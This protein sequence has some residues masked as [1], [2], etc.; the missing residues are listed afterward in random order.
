MLNIHPKNALISL[1]LEDFQRWFEKRYKSQLIIKRDKNNNIVKEV[2]L[3]PVLI[4]YQI[5]KNCTD[6]QLIYHLDEILWNQKNRRHFFRIIFSKIPVNQQENWSLFD[7]LKSS[8]C[9]PLPVYL[10][11]KRPKKTEYHKG[12][13]DHG[14]LGSDFSKILKEQARTEEYQ[15]ILRQEQKLEQDP[16]DF[17]SALLDLEPLPK[18]GDS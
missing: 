14:S 3:P 18:E 7:Y 15:E 9:L 8:D 11:K 1:I 17:L 10:P 6:N 16:I 4:Q 2:N 5:Y 12:Y 13:R